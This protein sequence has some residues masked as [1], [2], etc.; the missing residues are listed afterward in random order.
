MSDWQ[1]L[2]EVSANHNRIDDTSGLENLQQLQSVSLCD[3]LLSNLTFCREQRLLL[4]L[5]VAGNSIENLSGLENSKRLE[6]LDVSNNLIATA[7]DLKSL[8]VNIK[9]C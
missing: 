8:Q 2:L 1:Q 7:K 6:I 3:N 4:R 5:A 9:L